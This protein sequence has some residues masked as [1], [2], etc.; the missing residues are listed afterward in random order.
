MFSP[1]NCSP[2]QIIV[3]ADQ[4]LHALKPLLPAVRTGHPHDL[5]SLF[6]NANIRFFYHNAIVILF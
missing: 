4:A 6:E 1:V 2:S 5:F 3:L